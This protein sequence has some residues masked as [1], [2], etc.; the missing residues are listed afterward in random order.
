MK[1]PS[2]I[3]YL[4]ALALLTCALVFSAIAQEKKTAPAES[5]AKN[6]SGTWKMNAAK[7]KFAGDGGPQSIVITL[8]QQGQNL[9]ESLTIGGSQGERKFDLKYILDGKEGNNQLGDE[10]VKS[11]A[12]LEGDALVVNLKMS[13][14][15]FRR[16]FT[17]SEDGKV[18]TIVVNHT[19]TDGE[20]TDTV[21]LEKQ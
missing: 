18:M 15:T 11:I 9:S 12:K 7:S 17:L 10:Q 4:L 21:V 5:S 3:N 2:S 8:D 13:N 16:K 19:E 6:F 1:L 14:N 20:R